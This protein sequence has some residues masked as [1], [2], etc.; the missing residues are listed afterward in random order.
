[1]RGR[2]QFRRPN[3]NFEP[4]M[5]ADFQR[6]QASMQDAI[7]K[8]RIDGDEVF[9][10]ASA[11]LNPANLTLGPVHNTHAHHSQASS[12]NDTS[13]F[14]HFGNSFDMRSDRSMQRESDTRTSVSL[15][16]PPSQHS[17]SHSSSAGPQVGPLTPHS[18]PQYQNIGYCSPHGWPTG[19]GP[20]F[21]YPAPYGAYGGVL[22]QG[23]M[24]VIAAPQGGETASPST[25]MPPWA[26][27]VSLFRASRHIHRLIM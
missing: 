18:A 15:T 19:Y 26:S 27:M 10:F 1:M 4:R 2:G 9:D 6:S 23:A 12:T 17:A 25:A 22:P 11:Q 3:P 13:S 14:T 20:P 5:F 21:A 7:V 16:P 24:P 8:P